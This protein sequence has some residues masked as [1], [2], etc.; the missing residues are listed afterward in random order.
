[1]KTVGGNSHVEPG[2]YLC[3][4][5]LAFEVVGGQGGTLPGPSTRKF[6]SVPFP[7]LFLVIP[8]IGFAFLIFLPAIGV[9]LCIFAVILRVTGQVPTSRSKGEEGPPDPERKVS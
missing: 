6:V 9:V 1:M 8:V 7:L 4:D 2:Y 5:R 3:T